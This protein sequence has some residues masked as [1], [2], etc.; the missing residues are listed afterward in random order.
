M[1]LFEVNARISKNEKGV[2]A[3]SNSTHSGLP[4][5]ILIIAGVLVG[6]I[7]WIKNKR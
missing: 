1:D 7:I 3:D 4:W 2:D 5:I 6:V